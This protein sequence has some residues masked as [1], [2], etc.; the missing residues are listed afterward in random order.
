M[1][2]TFESSVYQSSFYLSQLFSSTRNPASATQVPLN[3]PTMP[4]R[5]PPHLFNWGPRPLPTPTSMLPS[6]TFQDSMRLGIPP[7]KEEPHMF[8]MPHSSKAPPRMEDMTGGHEADLKWPNGLTF[9]NALTGR[10]E[11]TK[12]MFDSDGLDNKAEQNHHLMQ[13]AHRNSDAS[14]MHSNGGANP[15]EF[16][17]LDSSGSK[18]ENKF[19]RSYTLP[20]RMT[21]S[22]S[23]TSLNHHQHNP[24]EYRN[25]A[26]MYSESMETFL[27]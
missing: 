7:S 8:L 3:Q 20:A 15:D 6:P 4:I 5:P 14:S 10:A 13:H 24:D 22:S 2:H 19:K 11:E 17:S 21:S 16:L 23:T 18:M 12:L 26:G 25:E 9:F 27:G 1:R